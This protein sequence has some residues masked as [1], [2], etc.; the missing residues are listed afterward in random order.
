MNLVG[1]KMGKLFLALCFLIGICDFSLVMASTDAHHGSLSDLLAPTVNFIILVGFIVFKLRGN[2][3]SYFLS[4]SQNVQ[5]INDRAEAKSKEAQLKYMMFEKKIKNSRTDCENIS[6]NVDTEIANFTKK[7]QV[8]MKDKSEKLKS[9]AIQR[10]EK[11]K[12]DHLQK[13]HEDF[14]D[15]IIQKA[16]NQIESD[17]DIQNKISKKILK[18]IQI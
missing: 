7:Y 10:L 3:K 5:T 14:L 15:S 18:G 6:Q 17:Q 9:D 11:E 1:N 4:Y 16:S 12:S 13:L 8:E 2:L